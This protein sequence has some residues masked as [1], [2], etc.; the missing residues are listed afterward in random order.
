M[1]IA[2]CIVGV[3]IQEIQIDGPKSQFNDKQI[4]YTGKKNSDDNV[5][6]KVHFFFLREGLTSPMRANYMVKFYS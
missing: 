3:Q 6:I 4:N 5:S 2:E 1:R